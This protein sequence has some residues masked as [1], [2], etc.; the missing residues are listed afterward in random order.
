MFDYECHDLSAVFAAFYGLRMSRTNAIS[1]WGSSNTK[2]N[3]QIN[4]LFQ[5][6]Y[7]F[8]F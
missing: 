2:A 7:I 4:E 8:I 5:Q 6:I 3:S 1:P